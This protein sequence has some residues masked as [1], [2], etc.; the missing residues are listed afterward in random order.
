MLATRDLHGIEP[1]NELILATNCF[2]FIFGIE[3]G[4]PWKPPPIVVFKLT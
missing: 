1:L 3:K 2:P 4:R